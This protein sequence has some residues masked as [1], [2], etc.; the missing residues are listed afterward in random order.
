MTTP[1]RLQGDYDSALTRASMSALAELVLALASYRD[2]LVL[3]GGWVPYLLVREHGRGDFAHVGSIDID[4]AVDPEGVDRDGYATI[5][6]LLEDRGYTGRLSRTGEPLPFSFARTVRWEGRTYSIQVDL[7]TSGEEGRRRH[8]HVQP[9]LPARIAKG[10]GLAFRHNRLM[11]IESVLPGGGR[12]ECEVRCLDIAG[13]I[14]MKGIV[15]GER[16][17]EKDAYDI[18]SVVGHCLGGPEE[19]AGDVAGHL[20]DEELSSGTDVIAQRFR[21]IEAEGPAWVASFLQPTDEEMRKRLTADAFV[22][23]DRF[24]RALREG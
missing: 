1:P 5:V 16:F 9:D 10:C 17:R 14:G 7:L 24:L 11:S 8:R 22:V 4:L 2:S 19:V 21:G 15:L 20:G 6:E 23:M 18:Y 3:V 12:A 13:C